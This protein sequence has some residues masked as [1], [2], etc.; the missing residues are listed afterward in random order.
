[1]EAAPP[2][3]FE[4]LKVPAAKEKAENILIKCHTNTNWTIMDQCGRGSGQLRGHFLHWVMFPSFFL[5][6][7][8]LKSEPATAEAILTEDNTAVGGIHWED[9]ADL[10]A[11]ALESEA[12]KRKV[13]SAV[14]PTITRTVNVEVNRGICCL[15]KE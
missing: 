2:T 14:N 6:L 4:A 7:G 5:L 15:A 10:V 1:V 8:G 3:V 12:C 11:K 13:L 9:V